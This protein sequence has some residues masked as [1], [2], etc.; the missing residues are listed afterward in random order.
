[1]AKLSSET[2]YCLMREPTPVAA[3]SRLN[4]IFCESRWQDR[5]VTMVLSIL[6]PAK[7]EVTLVNAGHMPPLIRRSS[8]TVEPAGEAAGGL[9]L[10]VDTGIEY[11]QFSLSLSPGDLLIMYTDGI[12]DAMNVA[13][14][15]YG[16]KRL[17]AQ[18][19]A[20]VDGVKALGTRI[21]DDV[22]RFVGNQPQSDDMCVTCYG[23]VVR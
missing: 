11:E 4:N 10:G 16:A 14:D 9:P 12:P 22:R 1:M 7:H 15:F 5:F 13:Q 19:S 21:L 23:R 17:E 20:T 8:G 18:L 2:R 6:D 3:V